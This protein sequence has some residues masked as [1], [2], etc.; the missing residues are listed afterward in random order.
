MDGEPVALVVDQN[1]DGNINNNDEVY[2]Y[3]GM[4]RGGKS[5]YAC[6]VSDPSAQP[7]LQWK[8][9]KTINANVIQLTVVADY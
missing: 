4:R 6:N 3:T 9:S 8:I 2:V 5:Y 7:Q 1:Y